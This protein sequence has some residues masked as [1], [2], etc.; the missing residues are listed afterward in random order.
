[1]CSARW[2]PFIWTAL[3]CSI[4]GA[5]ELAVQFQPMK[6]VFPQGDPIAVRMRFEN[7][8]AEDLRVELDEPHFE[9]DI[10]FSCPDK[11]AKPVVPG[12]QSSM[13]MVPE[14]RLKPRQSWDRVIAMRRFFRFGAPKRYEIAYRV[15][16]YKDLGGVGKGAPPDDGKIPVETLRVEDIEKELEARPHVDGNFSIRTGPDRIRDEDARQI[17]DDLRRALAGPIAPPDF[18]NDT[19]ADRAARGAIEVVCCLDHPLAIEGLELAEGKLAGADDTIIQ[20]LAG[21]ARTKEGREALGR[22]VDLV[23]PACVGIALAAYDKEVG[24]VPEAMLKRLLTSPNRTGRW[25]TVLFL[26]SPQI[27]TRYESVIEVLKGKIAPADREML[28]KAIQEFKL[29]K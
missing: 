1:M 6:D 22:A 25:Q 29:P 7:L 28:V 10:R 24:L 5:T 9:G 19:P 12:R 27:A 17:V 14:A 26:A 4:G 11:D 8:S 16:F 15:F 23:R 21:F 2:V 20:A 18:Y 3:A 13:Y